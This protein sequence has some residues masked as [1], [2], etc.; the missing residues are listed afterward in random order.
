MWFL[1][2]GHCL[3]N[4]S[5]F[6]LN[7]GCS[8]TLLDQRVTLFRTYVESVLWGC[9]ITWLESPT[10]KAS[11]NFKIY[12]THWRTPTH[13]RTQGRA[14]KK[15]S[16]D[17]GVSIHLHLCF[18]LSNL[19]LLFHAFLLLFHLCFGVKSSKLSMSFMFYGAVLCSNKPG[20]G[21]LFISVLEGS[22]I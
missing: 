16:S 15:R 3:V 6:C 5:R 18:S 21:P 22:G 10:S 20:R 19:C 14:E 13:G 12:E 8:L 9:Y 4:N 11:K 7:V 1:G 2:T 17:E